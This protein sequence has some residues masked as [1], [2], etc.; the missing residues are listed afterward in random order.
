MTRSL[1]ACILLALT[2]AALVLCPPLPWGQ[3]DDRPPPSDVIEIL[4]TDPGDVVARK[5]S[6]MYAF[7]LARELRAFAPRIGSPEFQGGFG[8]A[9]AA[10]LTPRT[11]AV[12]QA[13]AQ[14][15]DRRVSALDQA[16]AKASTPEAKAQAVEHLR[17]FF[18]DYAR[19]LERI[20][21]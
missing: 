5:V 17:S 18:L 20:G 15:F 11:V 21:R 16:I 4:S 2:G 9:G 12:L 14:G 8:S 19:E 10:A 3:H 13:S 6:R 7:S 1:M